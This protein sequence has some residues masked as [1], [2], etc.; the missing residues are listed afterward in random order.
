L[1]GVL[2]RQPEDD[3]WDKVLK[4]AQEYLD[5]AHGAPKRKGNL[6]RRGAFETLRCG[7]S[8]GGGQTQPMNLINTGRKAVVLEKLTTS[9]C[10]RR[11]AGFGS[12]MVSLA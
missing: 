11:I 7:V 4:A 8:H 12:C 9:R 6:H 5:Q 1:I 10:F 3:D 2:A